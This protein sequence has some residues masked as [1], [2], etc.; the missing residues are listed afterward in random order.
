MKNKDVIF[1]LSVLQRA[2]VK[3]DAAETSGGHPSP[4][5]VLV[6]SHLAS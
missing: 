3:I 2:C 5:G 6:G 1:D 4:A